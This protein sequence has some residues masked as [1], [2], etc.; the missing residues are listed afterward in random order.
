MQINSPAREFFLYKKRD[1]GR[2]G[3][4][5]ASKGCCPVTYSPIWLQKT[6]KRR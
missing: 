1:A 6:K 5:N 3:V 4:T 2:E